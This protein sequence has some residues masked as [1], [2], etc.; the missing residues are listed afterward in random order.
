MSLFPK[1]KW[2]VPLSRKSRF[3]YESC[4]FCASLY[5][6]SRRAV[7]FTNVTYTARMISVSAAS[8]RT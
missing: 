7:L 8:M 1:K 3:K 5:E 4:M 2:S 6:W